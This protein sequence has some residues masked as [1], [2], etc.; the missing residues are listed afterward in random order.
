MP[1]YELEYN[2]KRFEVEAPDKDTAVGTLSL[3]NSS[4]LKNRE[5]KV[6]NLISSRGKLTPETLMKQMAKPGIVAPLMG[7]L[8]AIGAPGTLMEAA[9]ANPMLELQA[10]RLRTIP[11]AIKQGLTGQRL[12]ELGDVGRVAGYPEP[13]NIGMGAAIVYGLP[14]IGFFKAVGSLTR[15]NKLAD[16]GLLRAGGEIVENTDN[17]LNF[18]KK[19][20]DNIYNGIKDYRVK[21]EKFESAVKDMPDVVKK[22]IARQFKV[23]SLED[24]IPNATIEDLRK[25]KQISGELKPSVFGKTAKGAAETIEGKRI[26]GAYSNVKNLIQ[27][28]IIDKASTAN[29]AQKLSVVAQSL[30]DADEAFTSTMKA[31]QFVKKT[32]VDKTTGL[33][34][35]AGSLAVKISDPIDSTARVALKR[36]RSVN[37]E[38]KN[39]INK[40][41]DSLNRFNRTRA[42]SEFGQSALKSAVFAGIVGSIGAKTARLVLG[43]KK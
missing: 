13:V 31:A 19:D 25:V 7:E 6:E 22:E 1:K 42:L 35:K 15:L 9:V 12:G 37:N 10:G 23:D 3:V 24:I 34:T 8:Q 17:A 11:S 43:D 16:R 18:L 36:I 5:R 39:G 26:S 4:P 32:I 29:E 21:P 30:L 27:E 28:T 38:V 20:I 2:G 14:V 33:A 40:S 41:V